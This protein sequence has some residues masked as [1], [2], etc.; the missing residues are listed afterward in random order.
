LQ[1]YVSGL[2]YGTLGEF[3]YDYHSR[4]FNWGD[5]VVLANDIREN[6]LSIDQFY[7]IVEY[8]SLKQNKDSRRAIMTTWYPWKDLGYSGPC[9]QYVQFIIRGGKLHMSV[10]FRSNDMLSALGANM[11]ALVAMQERMSDLLG[12]PIGTYTH[13]SVSAHVYVLRD[14]HELETMLMAEWDRPREAVRMWLQNEVTGIPWK[15]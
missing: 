14:Q 9:L 7:R 10:L 13:H 5:G 12:L 2:L 11:Y 8:L 6:E 1:E 4:L 15:V 3:T